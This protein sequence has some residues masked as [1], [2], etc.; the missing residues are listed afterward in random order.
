MKQ[1]SIRT[2][3]AILAL[4]M[5][6]CTFFTGCSGVDTK[7]AVEYE[8][9]EISRAVFQYL[10]CM[11]KT[12]YLYEAYGVTSSQITSSQL[13]DNPAI[14]SAKAEDGSTVSDTLKSQVLE[15]V[16]L[17]L[18]MKKVAEDQGYFLSAD[19]KKM[20][21]AEF[22]KI[23]EQYESKKNFNLQ[24]KNYGV[25]YDQM[26][27]YNY[28]Q[29]LAYQGQNLLFGED[30][31]MKISQEN[32]QKYYKNNYATVGCIYINTKTKTYANGKTVALPEEEK[33]EKEDLAQRVYDRMMAGE[34]FAALCLEFSDQKVDE[35]SALKGYT[36]KKGGFVSEEIENK[37]FGMKVG[38]KIKAETSGGVYL[39]Y[40][41]PLD[42][43]YFAEESENI[44]AELEEVKKFS[45]VAEAED[46][47]TVDED[48]LNELDIA[49]ILHVV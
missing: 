12:N 49:E 24:M 19:Q 20:V 32:A 15:E 1:N 16:K 46:Q 21:Q 33:K 45:L 29:T 34:D 26:L 25:N 38:E 27:E 31:T 9:A 18:Y 30:G 23:V 44:L 14:W 35:A 5:L 17:M 6:T 8:G 7:A 2:I 39:L 40:R 47:F 37:A 48:F 43:A 42:G 41:M 3:S 22:D 4:L 36:F 28:L 11:E 10:C 13:E